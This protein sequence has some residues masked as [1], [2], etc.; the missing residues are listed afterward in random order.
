[1]LALYARIFPPQHDY[2]GAT[3]EEARIGR[4]AVH[5][6]FR[7]KSLAHVLMKEALSRIERDFGKTSI[8]LNA[9]AHLEKLYDAHGFVREGDAFTEGGIPHVFMRRGAE[10]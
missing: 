5:K 7:G 3:F 8:I 6:K 4:V 1:M 10:A 9:Q 2:H